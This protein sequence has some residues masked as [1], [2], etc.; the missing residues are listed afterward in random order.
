MNK[1]Q[2]NTLKNTSSLPNNYFPPNN[3]P[4]FLCPLC[5]HHSPI[6]QELFID[7]HTNIPCITYKCTCKTV[8]KIS[9]P[10]L[11]LSLN[12]IK[13][14]CFQHSQLDSC[15][16]CPV[17]KLHMCN[18]CYNYHLYFKKEHTASIKQNQFEYE[19]QVQHI[20]AHLK[21]MFTKFN[22]Y[23]KKEIT[24]INEMINKML[25]LKDVIEQNQLFIYDT[26]SYLFKLLNI[27]YNDYYNF[28][29]KNESNNNVNVKNLLMNSK[30]II[31]TDRMFLDKV[32][33][34]FNKIIKAFN[35]QQKDMSHRVVLNVDNE[36]MFDNIC[37]NEYEG[38][39]RTTVST[40]GAVSIND[41]TN[42]SNKSF[43]KDIQV[44]GCLNKE[45]RYNNIN[46]N[47]FHIQKEKEDINYNA[48]LNEL[49]IDSNNNVNGLSDYGEDR[50]YNII[51]VSPSFNNTKLLDNNNS[52]LN[53]NN[54]NQIINSPLKNY[55]KKIRNILSAPNMN[56]MSLNE[57]NTNL[58]AMFLNDLNIPPISKQTCLYSLSHHNNQVTSIIQLK[59]DCNNNTNIM[60]NC[61]ITTSLDTNIILYNP[62]TF[63]PISKIP[64]LNLSITTILELNDSYLAIAYS[65]N[66]IHLFS[67][68]TN[69][70]EYILKGHSDIITSLI[71][72]DNSVLLSASVDGSIIVWD[73][74]EYKCIRTLKGHTSHVNMLLLLDVHSFVSCGNDG[75]I[76]I[77]NVSA[78]TSFKLTDKIKAHEGKVACICKIDENVIASGGEDHCIKVWNIKEGNCVGTLCGHN[79]MINHILKSMVS[80][81][82]RIV[83]IS[84]SD[85]KSVKIWNVNKRECIGEI[86]NAHVDKIKIV[87][88]IEDGKVLTGGENG[89]VKVWV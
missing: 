64:S 26:N 46:R 30:F 54:T 35:Q 84:V 8:Q 41:N 47:I 31:K 5:K 2:T 63:Q 19:T 36:N 3:L 23:I 62:F 33:L 57:S 4:P 55:Q 85:D 32:I 7:K 73:I 15:S 42:K 45:Y 22:T 44:N 12:N 18:S 87:K 51:P 10:H 37:N 68:L 72:F 69:Q 83:L 79:G 67:L 76:C 52:F 86:E 88:E 53:Y 65:D 21:T 1:Q 11:L 27:I 89:V 28:T 49:N 59:H 74:I 70:F 13:P 81:L 77:W 6:I 40:K 34:N 16:Y 80:D 39:T 14:K 60:Y 17:C 38:T 25:K 56:N 20:Q 71:Q 24:I 58:F 29:D 78:S 43:D 48:Y 9:I 61:I 75:L 66:N 50:Q 82:E